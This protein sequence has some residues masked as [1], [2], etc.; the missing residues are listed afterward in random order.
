MKSLAVILLILICTVIVSAQDAPSGYTNNYRFRMWNEGAYPSADSINKNLIDI[1]STLFKRD[2]R[3]DSLKTAFTWM[4]NFPSG[5]WK[6]YDSN[7]FDNDTLK[8]KSG[9]FPK[10]GTTN[11][12]T[13]LNTF[14]GGA[15]K[16]LQDFGTSLNF[17]YDND[18]GGV[19]IKKNGSTTL[20]KFDETD[21]MYWQMPYPLNV[22]GTITGT[23]FSG[24]GSSLTS[25]NASNIS[26]GTLSDSRLS[27]NIPR[28][29][30]SNTYSEFQRFQSGVYY[31]KIRHTSAS[32]DS[33]K[34]DDYIVI[35]TNTSGLTVIYLPN[36]VG[37]TGREY[38]I[39]PKEISGDGIK[40]QSFGGDIDGNI[41][42]SF[43]TISDGA[44]FVSDGTNWYSFGVSY[45]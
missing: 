37:R 40:V 36:A 23:T 16:F 31:T 1:D 39:K 34:T 12:F 42:V 20:M 9:V 29:D 33:C 8:V 17:Y 41:A 7:E 2:L 5:T 19:F 27:S 22:T 30:S 18:L 25:L 6:R 38:R 4:F 26:S 15:V 11:T 45:P 14:T 13:Q 44:L 10:L 32:I 35:V 21:G 43:A 3:I 24:S 28:K